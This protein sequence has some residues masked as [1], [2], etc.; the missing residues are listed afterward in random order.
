M[1]NLWAVLGVAIV[2]VYIIGSGLWVNTGDGWYRS[3][4]APSWQPPPAIFGII[5]PYNFIV[6]V[7]YTHLTLPTNREV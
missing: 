2:F 5:W 4:N 1:K 6:P 3:L 7:S